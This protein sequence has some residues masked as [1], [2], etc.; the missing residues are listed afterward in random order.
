M[1]T[2]ICN[3]TDNRP[4]RFVSFLFF[5]N[6]QDVWN[7]LGVKE[8]TVLYVFLLLFLQK[9]TFHAY[10]HVHMKGYIAQR[11]MRGTI[12]RD[13]KKRSTLIWEQIK[14]EDTLDVIT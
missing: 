13:K 10:I 12:L 2:N 8:K 6:L 14:I 3:A 1:A 7:P 9:R 11:T 5:I 4:L